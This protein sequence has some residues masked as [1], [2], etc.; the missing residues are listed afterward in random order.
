MGPTA[1]RSARVRAYW[2]TIKLATFHPRM[3][4][5]E[6]TAPV[7]YRDARRFWLVTVVILYVPLLRG[8][9]ASLGE[10][11]GDRGGGRV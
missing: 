7:S 4:A 1:G 11:L 2:R 8:R 9:D 5:A 6:L 3:L 10:R